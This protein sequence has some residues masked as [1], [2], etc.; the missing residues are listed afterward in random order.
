MLDDWLGL[1]PGPE[2]IELEML[3]YT[4]AERRPGSRLSCQIR[5]RDEIDGIRLQVPDCQL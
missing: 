3:D 4:A 5:M 2:P 1:L